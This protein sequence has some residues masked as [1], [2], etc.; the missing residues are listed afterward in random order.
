MIERDRLPHFV[1]KLSSAVEESCERGPCPKGTGELWR[2]LNDE[3]SGR[4]ARLVSLIR[5]ALVY[6]PEG[7][8]REVVERYFKRQYVEH[9]PFDPNKYE[10]SERI[11]GGGEAKVYLLKNKH[12]GPSWALKLLFPPQKGG[13]L[14]DVAKHFQTNYEKLREIYASISEIIPESANF[15]INDPFSNEPRAAMIQRLVE[16]KLSNFFSYT[17]EDLLRI[18]SVNSEFNRQL[19]KF[20]CITLDYFEK[21]GYMVETMGDFNLCINKIGGEIKGIHILDMG[22]LRSSEDKSRRYRL[23]LKKR[24]DFLKKLVVQGSFDCET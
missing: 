20:T 3:S 18:A 7:L 9:L 5:A 21:T 13:S 11:G 10:F 4:Y 1:R 2:R 19:R 14:V 16:G 8:G 23:M 24:V 17:V 12:K 6:A 22:D 15:I